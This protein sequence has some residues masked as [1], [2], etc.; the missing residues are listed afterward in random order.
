MKKPSPPPDFRTLFHKVVIERSDRLTEI[1]KAIPAGPSDPYLPWDKMRFKEPPAGLTREEWWLGVKFVRQQM[2]RTLPL[3]DKEGK[4]F[5]FALPDVLLKA[6]EGINRDTSGQ[7]AISEQ[8]TNPATRDR[9]LVNSLIEE[10]INSSQLEGAATTRRVA[11]EMIRTG[12]SP[13]DRDE[14]MILNNYEAM[15]FI[16]TIREERLTPDLIREIHRIVTKGTLSNPDAAGRFQLPGEDRIGVFTDSGLELHQPPDAEH[17]PQRIQLLCDFA[18]GEIGD[19]YVPPVLRAITLHFMLGYEHPF[20]DG[21]GR[22]A[23]AIFYWSMLSQGYWLTEFIVIS[24]ILKGAPSRYAR[25]YLYAEDENDLTYFYLYQIE[26]LQRAIKQ[27]HQYLADKM[28]ELRKLQETVSAAPSLFNPR[29]V[30]V[31]EHALKKPNANFTAKSHKNSHD[32]VYETAR[33]DLMGL[34]KLGLLNRVRRGRE[35]VW[36]PVG[37]LREALRK[38]ED[39]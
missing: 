2:Q 23:R 34:E 20:E 8:V 27:L 36:T 37:N 35:F 3:M 32:V 13:R 25:S 12:R 16:G 31:L 19:G 29:Q 14:R 7:I 38:L 10:A 30:A 24:A 26:V 18:N 22:T 1:L 15:R 9:Y 5:T 6:L 4:A 21:N 17:L 39:R 11:K 28:S 33:Q